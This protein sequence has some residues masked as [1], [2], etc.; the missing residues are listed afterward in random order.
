MPSGAISAASNQASRTVDGA[1]ADLEAPHARA[2]GCIQ[3]NLHVN[4]TQAA[5]IALDQKLGFIQTDRKTYEIRDQSFDTALCGKI[6][7]N[8]VPG[9]LLIVLN[10]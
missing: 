1:G 10:R 6:C 5:T 9:P 3:L 7:G 2:S 8:H 4:A